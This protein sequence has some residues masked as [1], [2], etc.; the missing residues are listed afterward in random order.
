MEHDS[1]VAL[2]RDEFNFMCEI[3]LDNFAGSADVSLL[4]MCTT[5]MCRPHLHGMQVWL[6]NDRHAQSRRVLAQSCSLA[7]AIGDKLD[8]TF[9]KADIFGKPKPQATTQVL[10]VFDDKPDL[11]NVTAIGEQLQ[12]EFESVL[13]TV[14]TVLSGHDSDVISGLSTSLSQT[15]SDA[16]GNV[17]GAD[18]PAISYLMAELSHALP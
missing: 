3:A 14:N 1:F 7:S 5:V 8:A 6:T 9:N 18:A 17:T 12:D 11:L 15:A 10:F 16:V 13:G 2:S 4:R